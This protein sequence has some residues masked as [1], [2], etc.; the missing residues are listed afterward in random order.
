MDKGLWETLAVIT[1][2]IVLALVMLYR[3]RK[4]LEA[5]KSTIP[6]DMTGKR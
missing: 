4:K 1:A 5:D 2:G 6:L 3:K